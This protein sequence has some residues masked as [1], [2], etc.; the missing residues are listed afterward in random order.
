MANA[1]TAR[2]LFTQPN[3]RKYIVHLT[4]ISDGTNESAAVKVDRSALTTPAGVAPTAIKIASVRWNIQGI[5][6]VKLY[7]DHTNDDTALVLSGNGYDN[8]E[9][10][11]NLVDP[12]TD[13]EAVTGAIGDLVLTTVGAAS[14]GSY[15]ITLECVI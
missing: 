8:F 10:Y 15:D 12:N 5:T 11:G 13:V 6:Y 9:N 14:G 7:W 4:L 1:V 3:A 2:L